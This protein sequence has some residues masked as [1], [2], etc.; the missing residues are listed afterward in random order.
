[1]PD[2]DKDLPEL[3]PEIIADSVSDDPIIQS[4]LCAMLRDKWRSHSTVRDSFKNKD[5]RVACRAWFL[6]WHPLVA[7]RK[8]PMRFN[9]PPWLNMSLDPDDPLNDTQKLIRAEEAAKAYYAMGVQ[10]QVHSMIEWC[11]R[12]LTWPLASC[13]DSSTSVPTAL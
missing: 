8:N 2:I 10:T 11:R 6:H 4:R 3:S 5:C 9:M 1:M 13:T 12:M 7:S